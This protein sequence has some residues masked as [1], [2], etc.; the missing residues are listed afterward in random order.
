M[1]ARA[2]AAVGFGGKQGGGAAVRGAAVQIQLGGSRLAGLARRP[3]D[4]PCKA[5]GGVIRA[6]RGK[7]DGAVRGL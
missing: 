4:D 3:A 6:F 7:E 2:V 5:L 1:R